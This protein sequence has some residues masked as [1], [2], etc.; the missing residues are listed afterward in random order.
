MN[1]IIRDM[2]FIYYLSAILYLM[3]EQLK[4]VS[5]YYTSIVF[6]HPYPPLDIRKPA[7]IGENSGFLIRL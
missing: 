1:T 7:E 3:S 5:T 2:L 4:V 6:I